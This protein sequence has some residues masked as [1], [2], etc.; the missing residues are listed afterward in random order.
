[1]RLG[2]LFLYI[3]AAFAL[4]AFGSS[5]I[6]GK[7]LLSGRRASITTEGKKGI[8]VAFMSS[9]CPCSDSH[10][11]ELRRLAGD[12]KEFAFAA[13]HSNAD[14]A[15]S[16]AKSYFQKKALGFP[17]LQDTD[18]KLLERF[19]ALKTP[20]AFIL[21]ADGTIAYQGGVTDS[22]KIERATKNFLRDALEDL[23]GQRPVR[24]SKTRTLGCAIARG[25]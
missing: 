13:V 20:H 7:D 15:E 16:E 8:V 14:E 21:L 19:R 6:D 11:A 1:M 9:K 25:M 23:Q 10:S 5:S 4:N 24:E 18:Q 3:S 2:T 12:F 17:V 22:V